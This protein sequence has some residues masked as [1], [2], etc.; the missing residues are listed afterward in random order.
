MIGF[1][2]TGSF[3]NFERCF[4]VLELLCEKYEVLPIMSYNAYST[5]TRFGTAD[6]FKER[7]KVLCKKEIVH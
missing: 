4:K 7:A 3:C 6:Y 2:L 1:A 5:D